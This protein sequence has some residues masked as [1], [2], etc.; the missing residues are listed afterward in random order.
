MSGGAGASP[1]ALALPPKGLTKL[2][3]AKEEKTDSPARLAF[4]KLIEVY[5]KQ[6]PAKYELKKAELEKKLSLIA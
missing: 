1:E 5:K 3:M 4:L 6:N 2:T